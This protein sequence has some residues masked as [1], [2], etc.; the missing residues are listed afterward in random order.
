M[1]S[2][3]SKQHTHIMLQIFQTAIKSNI[4]SKKK[5]FSLSCLWKVNASWKD[6]MPSNAFHSFNLSRHHSLVWFIWI[7]MKTHSEPNSVLP[8]SFFVWLVNSDAPTQETSP[9]EGASLHCLYYQPLQ[10]WRL[11][12][13]FP[14]TIRHNWSRCAVHRQVRMRVGLL[15]SRLYGRNPCPGSP[16]IGAV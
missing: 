15:F 2:A 7:P 12:G 5:N 13:A 9:E 14:G 4:L 6:V 11:S 1:S 8:C 3:K 16:K 10:S